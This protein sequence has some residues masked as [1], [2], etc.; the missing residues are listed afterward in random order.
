MSAGQ[1]IGSIINGDKTMKKLDIKT[2]IESKTTVSFDGVDIE[3]F[4][5][6][7]CDIAHDA[8]IA[9][10]SHRQRNN[11]PDDIF[12]NIEGPLCTLLDKMED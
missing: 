1:F 5:Q 9:L 8:L 11:L 4:L 10:S 6:E 12:D 2:T 7:I 3:D